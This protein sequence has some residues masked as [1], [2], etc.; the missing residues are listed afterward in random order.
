[1]ECVL[2]VCEREGCGGTPLLPD[3][4]LNECEAVGSHVHGRDGHVDGSLLRS[5]AWTVRRVVCGAADVKTIGEC[6]KNMKKIEC[7]EHGMVTE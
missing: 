5:G 7:E 1:M 3:G 4:R 6:N 2:F